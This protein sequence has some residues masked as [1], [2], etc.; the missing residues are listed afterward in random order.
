[1][2]M[3][4]ARNENAYDVNGGSDPE[5]GYG[6]VAPAELLQHK[7]KKHHPG[8]DIS[9]KQIDEDL[10]VAE[11]EGSLPQTTHESYYETITY[12]FEEPQIQNVETRERNSLTMER[13]LLNIC[14]I[15]HF[16]YQL[17]SNSSFK[18]LK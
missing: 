17:R 10:A 7:H 18:Q 8:K 6:Y 4:P 14:L 1:M 12:E 11:K 2:P 9:E 13:D 16:H 3:P 5:S 15:R